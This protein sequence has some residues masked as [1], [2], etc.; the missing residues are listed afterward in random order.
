MAAAS[1]VQ[2]RSGEEVIGRRPFHGAE[3]IGQNDEDPLSWACCRNATWARSG[4]ERRIRR[5]EVPANG[6]REEL[7]DE[8]VPDL[9]R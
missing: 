6:G 5:M 9:I 2:R 4:P 7:R 8:A 1:A 3:A